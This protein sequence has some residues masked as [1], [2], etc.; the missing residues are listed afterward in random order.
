MLLVLIV[1]S[2]LLAFINIGFIVFTLV[3]FKRLE[4]KLNILHSDRIH[5]K[6]NESD[7]WN[8]EIKR[9]VQLQCMQVRSAVQK[10]IDD[11][12][13]KEIE[14]APKSLSIPLEKLS[15]VYSE[16]QLKVIHTFWEIYESYLKTH[17]LTNNGNIKNV[18]SGKKED[19]ESNVFKLHSASQ[20]L[21]VELTT[22]F[23]EIINY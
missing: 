19:T 12:H 21:H 2:I 4:N 22:L 18:F 9:T 8:D 13:K 10:Q 5:N 1:L 11:I 20:R 3:K 16:D 23:E 17:W 6:N 7:D 14:F 15:H